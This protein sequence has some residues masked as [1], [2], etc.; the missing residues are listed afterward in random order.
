MQRHNILIQSTSPLVAWVGLVMRWLM[1]DAI[2]VM[3]YDVGL[4]NMQLIVLLL[5]TGRSHRSFQYDARVHEHN[6]ASTLEAERVCNCV[7]IA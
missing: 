1:G 2:T 7:F 4:L 6:N 3:A 5:N